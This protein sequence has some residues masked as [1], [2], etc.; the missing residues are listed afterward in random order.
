MRV[1]L[2]ENI[3]KIA[4]FTYKVI[5]NLKKTYQNSFIMKNSYIFVQ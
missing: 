3:N 1:F 2:D 4:L 5:D